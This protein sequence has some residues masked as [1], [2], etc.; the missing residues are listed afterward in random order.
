[1]SGVWRL[2]VHGPVD[3][4]LNMA[5]DR[6]VQL[7]REEGSAPPTLRLYRWSRPT[8]TLGRFQSAGDV[9]V[10]ACEASGVDVVRRFT[11]GRAVL[12]DDEVTYSVVASTEDGVPR[13]VAASY[14]HLSAA[15]VSAYNLL[16]V[17]AQ[18]STGGAVSV[19]SPACYLLNTQADLSLGSSKL[20]GSA[21]V[22]AGSTVLQHGSFTR[23]RN[24]ER[25]ALVLGLTAAES[26]LM[27][28]HA[29][30]LADV[31]KSTPSYSTIESAVIRAFEQAL[32]VEL[33]HGELSAR[34]AQLASG[35]LGDVRLPGA[36][37]DR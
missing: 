16:G 37:A 30:V 14:R 21:Q 28:R 22:W 36:G 31:V 32:S 1:M 24:V 33:R 13:G 29:V 20:S 4:A 15:L 9:S 11:G 18:M 8:V 12:H 26:D 23:S 6:A 19:S 34:E 2:I 27:R 3:G 35:L 25:D 10:S 5:L 7:A 17:D